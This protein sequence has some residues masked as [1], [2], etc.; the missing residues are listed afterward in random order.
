MSHTRTSTSTAARRTTKG[1]CGAAALSVA[2]FMAAAPALAHVHVEADH[3]EPGEETVLTF[4][5]PNESDTGSPTTQVSVAL[6]NLTAVSTEAMPGWTVRLDR[7]VAAGT[8]RS[9]TWTAAPGRDDFRPGHH[10]V[11][12]R[13]RG[14]SR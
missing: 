11:V 14:V 1:L 10:R 6:P 8:V 2:A 5:V 3:I 7:D 13:G 4:D 9:I 12:A